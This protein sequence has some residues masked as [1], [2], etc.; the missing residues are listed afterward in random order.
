MDE[1]VFKN[2]EPFSS[3]KLSP[4]LNVIIF[5][6][7]LLYGFSPNIIP[8]NSIKK[9]INELNVIKDEEDK[10]ED[11]EDKEDKEEDKEYKKDKEEKEDKE[12]KE[13]KEEKQDINS[14]INKI[15]NKMIVLQ[16]MLEIHF[17]HSILLLLDQFRHYYTLYNI[18]YTGMDLMKKEVLN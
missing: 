9:E 5:E 14:E 6:V 2:V 15:M 16:N 11:K 4:F 17:F 18:H 12:N 7:W 13:Y 10:E 8:N 1:Y 3:K